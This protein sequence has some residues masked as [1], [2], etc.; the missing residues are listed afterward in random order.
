MVGTNGFDVP[1]KLPPCAASYQFTVY[2]KPGSSTLI[3]EGAAPLHT[4]ALI[5][6]KG[7]AIKGQGQLCGFRAIAM[8]QLASSDK[9]TEAP[10]SVGIPLMVNVP[11]PLSVAV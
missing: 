1:T 7:G 10:L 6:L 8:L 9:V 5:G 4:V 11:S 3:P 2:P